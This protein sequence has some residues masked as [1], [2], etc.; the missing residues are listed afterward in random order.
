[1]P[2]D[3]SIYEKVHDALKGLSDFLESPAYEGVK[4]LIVQMAGRFP[5]IGVVIGKL[6]SLMGDFRTE[7]EKLDVDDA[8]ENAPGFL[9]TVAQ[10]L[11]S[12]EEMFPAQAP[13]IDN[14]ELAVDEIG[15]VIPLLA[16]TLALVLEIQAKLDALN[17]SL[18]APA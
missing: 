8:L 16:E 11:S 13:D 1:M 5:A 6:S 14:V 12:A 18:P 7:L 2:V 3:P 15:K 4:K 10:L 9:A 17:S